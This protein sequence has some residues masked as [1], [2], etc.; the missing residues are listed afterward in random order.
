MSIDGTVCVLLN[1]DF[2]KTL[3]S[4]VTGIFTSRKSPPFLNVTLKAR[5]AATST[6]VGLE[7]VSVFVWPPETASVLTSSLPW[8]PV[9]LP[10]VLV[11]CRA[12]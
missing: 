5:F 7:T 12:A 11:E 3:T 2:W 4:S 10:L 9:T 8:I 6:V 1:T